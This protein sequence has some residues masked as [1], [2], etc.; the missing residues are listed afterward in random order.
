MRLF[1]SIVESFPAQEPFGT[2]QHTSRCQIAIL[3]LARYRAGLLE[4]SCF[5]QR[6]SQTA[7]LDGRFSIFC[8]HL[9]H[10]LV[11]H[12]NGTQNVQF[13]LSQLFRV[14]V[15]QIRLF[16][17][18]WQHSGDISYNLLSHII[19]RVCAALCSL[20]ACVQ[21]DTLLDIV[22]QSRRVVVELDAIHCQFV[23]AIGFVHYNCCF[24]WHAAVRW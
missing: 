2:T 17:R 3:L 8:Q 16:R 18:V 14:H 23:V 6:V 13:G 22:A 10:Y 4:H 21:S 12:R 15:Q 9:L 19:G 11:Y 20:A 5:G 1:S 24:A 7:G